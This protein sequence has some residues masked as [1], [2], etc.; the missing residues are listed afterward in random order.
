MGP[1]KSQSYKILTRGNILLMEF[2]VLYS[3][4]SDANICIIVNVVFLQKT[5]MSQLCSMLF[6]CI[7]FC[8]DP[9]LP[10]EFFAF[11]TKLPSKDFTHVNNSC[12]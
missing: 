11:N 9:E 10:I 12:L 2:V 3:K 4:A 8:N 5:Q 1:K 7:F 6:V